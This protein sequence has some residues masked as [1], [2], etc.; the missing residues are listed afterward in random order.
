MRPIPRDM[1]QHP[2]IVNV[3]SYEVN[4]GVWLRKVWGWRGSS[5]RSDD[6]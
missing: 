1:L 3:M 2:W 5:R 6:Q 4:M